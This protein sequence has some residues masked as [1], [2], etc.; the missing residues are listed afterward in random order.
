MKRRRKY[1]NDE[2]AALRVAVTPV[3]KN[4]LDNEAVRISRETNRQI[5]ASHIVRALIQAYYEKRLAGFI[6]RPEDQ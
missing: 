5:Y 1:K 2:Y 4:F 3:M 6:G